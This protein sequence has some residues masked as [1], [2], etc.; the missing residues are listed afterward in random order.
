MRGDDMRSGRMARCFA[1]ALVLLAGCVYP[2]KVYLSGPILSAD[3]IAF[4]DLKDTD[5]T[6]TLATLGQPVWE[7]THSRVLLYLSQTAI[8]WTGE[9]IGPDF[10]DNPNQPVVMKPYRV[11]ETD[12]GRVKALFVA[13]DENG[14]VTSHSVRTIRPQK[15][16][17]Y[18]EL[19]E[20]YAQRATKP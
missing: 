18:E 4:L 10:T 11:N 12:P 13:Y 3:A 17:S 20:Q 16:A 7:S 14:L 19:C 1:L 8:H 2:H 9:A 15:N 6:E 5:R